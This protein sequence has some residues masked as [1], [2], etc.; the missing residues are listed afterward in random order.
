MYGYYNEYIRHMLWE[1]PWGIIVLPLRCS[2][3]PKVWSTQWWSNS[4]LN[5]NWFSATSLLTIAPC[6]S[7]IS[8]FMLFMYVCVCVVMKYNFA[9]MYNYNWCFSVY[10]SE[11]RYCNSLHYLHCLDCW[12]DPVFWPKELWVR[13]LATAVVIKNLESWV[14]RR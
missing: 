4:L 1:S 7:A 9:L 5:C 10:I 14:K 6:W 3:M 11:R 12:L 8:P 13:Y 2:K